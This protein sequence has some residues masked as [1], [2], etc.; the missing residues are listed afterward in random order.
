MTIVST[1]VAPANATHATRAYR[2]LAIKSIVIINFLKKGM[3]N[4]FFIPSISNKKK[5]RQREKK[6]SVVRRSCPT[7]QNVYRC[8]FL[9]GKRKESQKSER[10]EQMI[11]VTGATGL[12]GSEVVRRLS[13]RG[14]PVRA[15]VRNVAK[16]RELSLLPHVEIVEGDMAHPETLSGALRGVE[17]AMLISSSDPAMLEVQSNFIEEA[18]QAGVRHVVKLSGIMPELDS[19]FR[20]ARMHGEI[21]RRLEAS[22]MAFTHLRSGEFMHA[23]FRQVPSIIARKT[24][25]LPMEDAKIASID[26]GDVAEVAVTILTGQGHEGKIYPLTGPETLSMAEVAEKLSAATGERIQYV[27]VTAEEAKRANLAAGMPPYTADALVELFA[28]RRKGKEAQVSPLIQ[29]I[30]G[31]RPTSFDE[32]ALRHVAIFRGERPVSK[33]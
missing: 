26:V 18:R 4:R 10:K 2:H 16:A 22:G 17:R 7:C 14:V 5:A 20:F 29:T 13:A 11:L 30:F 28:E 6:R 12:N 31:W 9:P 21:E 1:N 27:N 25:F 8:V 23:Y 24:M 32:F 19:P 3:L 15:L 33:I